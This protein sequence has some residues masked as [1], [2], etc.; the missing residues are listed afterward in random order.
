MSSRFI[1][2]LSQYGPSA[3]TDALVD[4][5]AP[6]LVE[7]FGISCPIEIPPPRMK[8]ISAALLGAEPRSVFLTG[9]A[10][11]G[12]TFHLRKFLLE[13]VGSDAETSTIWTNAS[14]SGGIIERDLP[15]GRKLRIIRD[16][17]ALPAGEKIAQVRAAANS[18]RSAQPET[19]FLVAANDG[20]LLDSFFAAGSDDEAGS[21]C[22]K[23]YQEMIRMMR[24][25]QETP[26]P[27]FAFSM[28]NLSHTLDDASLD[29]LLDTILG[30]PDWESGCSSCPR[31]AEVVNPCPIRYNRSLLIGSDGS[32]SFRTRIKTLVRLAAANDQHIPI[33][34]LLML[35]VNVLLGSSQKPGRPL[36]NCAT[37]IKAKTPLYRFTNPYNNACGVNI[38]DPEK[39]RKNPFFAMVA[40]LGIGMETDNEIDA[41]LLAR[42]TDNPARKSL[43]EKDTIYGDRIFDGPLDHYAKRGSERQDAQEA[44]DLREALQ[45]QRRRLFFKLGDEG[46]S[47]TGISPWRL[48][49]FRHAGEYEQICTALKSGNA[50]GEALRQ[51]V[52][53]I[54]RTLTGL[55]ASDGEKLWLTGVVGRADGT[56]GRLAMGEPLGAVASSWARVQLQFDADRSCPALVAAEKGISRELPRL[57]I[58]PL[59]FEYLKRVA[60]GSLPSS[61]SRQCHQEIRHFAVRLASAL[62]GHADQETTVIRMVDLDAVGRLHENILE[63][64]T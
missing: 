13:L 61:F 26:K 16:V 12:K 6:V 60:G 49:V 30:H 7:E 58:T 11:D 59:L 57:T 18:I 45:T 48:T 29:A 53:G 41:L 40:S 20:Q 56:G 25:G 2:F 63:I 3:A 35:I 46:S 62:Y 50:S 4:E 37:I 31:A 17:S 42:H 1:D 43:F 51:I 34:Y 39:R 9:T 23:I 5:H 44:K 54:N 33:R 19:I 8:E 38:R 36:L 55:M 64:G 22:R 27:D 21:L 28:F 14:N 47:G 52:L 32:E 15:S 24:T 10:G